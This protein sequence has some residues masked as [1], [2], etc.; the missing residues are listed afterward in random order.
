MDGEHW[1]NVTPLMIAPGQRVAIE[2]LNPT[3]MP[4][5]MHLRGH[6]FRV[7]AIDRG[8]L[9]GAVRDIVLVPR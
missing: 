6:A 1:P 4:H 3:M 2:M 7:V 8:P 5:P 9:A